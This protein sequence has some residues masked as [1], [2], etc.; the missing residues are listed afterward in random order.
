MATDGTIH[1]LSDDTL[2][3]HCLTYKKKLVFRLVGHHSLDLHKIWNNCALVRNLHSNSI[4]I[5]QIDF[6]FQ[7]ITA[8]VDHVVLSEKQ[9]VFLRVGSNVRKS[10]IFTSCI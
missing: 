2:S 3:G 6:R 5:D 10:N 1:I 4:F 9:N 8:T 7:Q